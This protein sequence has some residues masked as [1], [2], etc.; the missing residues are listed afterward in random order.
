MVGKV[1]VGSISVLNRYAVL[2]LNRLD[3]AVYKGCDGVEPDN[4]DG[5]TNNT[6][7]ILTAE[8]QLMYNR[9]L[10]DEAHERGLLIA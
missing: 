9:F 3:V 5:Y 6:G 10:A 2:W 4:V 1:N 8:D 7:F